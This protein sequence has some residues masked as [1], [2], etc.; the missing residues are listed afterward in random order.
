MTEGETILADGAPSLRIQ[1][2]DIYK[3]VAGRFFV[4]HT[5]YGRVG[6]ADVGGIELIRYDPETGRFRTHFFGVP[7]PPPLGHVTGIQALP[8]QHRALLTGRRRVVLG[9][10]VQLVLRGESPPSGLLGHLRIRALLPLAG[11]PSSTAGHHGTVERGHGHL[12]DISIPALGIVS[13]Y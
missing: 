11:H 12:R 4:V 8:A 7:G 13:G 3:W 2:S 10:H 9:H 6:D 5:A 1:A